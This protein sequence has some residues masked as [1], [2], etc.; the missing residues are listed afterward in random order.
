[1]AHK[2]R[3]TF[4]PGYNKDGK[5]SKT[6]GTFLVTD[7][8]RKK[9]KIIARVEGTNNAATRA[10]I[11]KIVDEYRWYEHRRHVMQHPHDKNHLTKSRGE[12][13]SE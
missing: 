6:K 13:G 7:K 8:T 3:V 2:I 12:K 10:D 9:K 1:M 5:P 4:V 11:Q